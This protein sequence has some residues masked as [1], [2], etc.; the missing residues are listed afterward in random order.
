MEDEEF[1]CGEIEIQWL[2]RRLPSL[3][4]ARPPAETLRAAAIAGALLVERERAAPRVTAVSSG[5]GAPPTADAWTL[6]AR[7]DG[8]RD[9]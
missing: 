3:V 8:M 9:G 4:A 6:A 2:E 1:R 7:H 5:P